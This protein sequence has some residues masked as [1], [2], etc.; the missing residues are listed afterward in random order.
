MEVD[1]IQNI[2]EILKLGKKMLGYS[3]SPYSSFP[4]GSV[5]IAENGEIFAGCNVENV[6]YS[7]TVCAEV[8]AISKMV[9]SGFQRLNAIFIFSS[10]EQFVTP[11]GACRQSILEFAG[12]KDIPI[13]TVN[14]KGDIRKHQ[15]SRL[16]PHAF[17]FE[18]LIEG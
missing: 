1:E 12:S 4:V 9:S 18:R 3:Y 13:F 8:C 2:G 5:A 11:C 6:S 7:L 17:N 14:S 10:T 16:I 15:L